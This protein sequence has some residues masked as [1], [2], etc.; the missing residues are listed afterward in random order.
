MYLSEVL[1]QTKQF[2]TLNLTWSRNFSAVSFLILIK[3]N[4][5]SGQTKENNN[6]DIIMIRLLLSTYFEC[7]SVKN[8]IHEATVG[9][10]ETARKAVGCPFTA[11]CMRRFWRAS[12]CFSIFATIES[13]TWKGTPD[14]WLQSQFESSP[15]VAYLRYQHP[16]DSYNLINKICQHHLWVKLENMLEKS[17]NQNEWIIM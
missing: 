8:L 14:F 15:S 7:M 17:L 12:D 16:H 13:K 9:A 4:N 10:K 3:F 2:S 1:Q 5:R 6:N 11:S